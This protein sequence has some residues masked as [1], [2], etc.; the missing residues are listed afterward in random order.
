MEGCREMLRL[1]GAQIHGSR[2]GRR[3][4]V[5]FAARPK[6]GNYRQRVLLRAISPIAVVPKI[7]LMIPSADN[8][9]SAKF[10]KKFPR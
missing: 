7:L 10:V 8:H 3:L 6:I 2:P 1:S 9:L 5:V 4:A